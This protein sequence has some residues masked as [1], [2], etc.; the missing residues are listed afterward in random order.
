[1]IYDRSKSDW[2]SIDAEETD[3]KSGDEI[4]MRMLI[5]AFEPFGGSDRNASAEVLRQLPESITGW[6][7]EKAVL[8][9]V[10]GEAGKKA[11]QHSADCYILLGE[12]GGRSTVTPELK[13][14][15]VRHARIPDNAG[16]QPEN[17]VILEGRP[18][19]YYT[20]IPVRKIVSQM[21]A[22]GY[23]VAV[24][25]DAGTY[26]CNDTFFLVG[27]NSSVPVE[28]IHVPADVGKAEE[29]ARTVERFI[30]YVIQSQL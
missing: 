13:A 25:E 18:E 23:P 8:P 26:V 27:M 9:V 2:K 28:F 12:A 15:N 22:E 20:A 5:T 14:R 17:E 29:F 3:Q 4:Q 1:M 30:E 11:L 10:F 6:K 24:S 16:N 19:A 21:Q 7:I